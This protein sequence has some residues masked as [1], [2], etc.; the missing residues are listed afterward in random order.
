MEEMAPDI[1]PHEK[2]IGI[3]VGPTSNLVFFLAPT[4]SFSITFTLNSC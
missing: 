4:Y 1:W 3:V 2:R